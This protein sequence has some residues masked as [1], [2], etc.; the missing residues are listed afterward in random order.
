MTTLQL[1]GETLVDQRKDDR[2][3]PLKT[4][5]TTNWPMRVAVMKTEKFFF[6]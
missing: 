1:L 6:D 2:P 4:E 5:Q 3:A